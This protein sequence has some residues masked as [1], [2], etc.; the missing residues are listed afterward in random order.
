MR[1]GRG[2]DKKVMIMARCKEKDEAGNKRRNG[3]SKVQQGWKKKSTWGVAVI[4]G[5]W[6]RSQVL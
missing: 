1:T 2:N 4:T 6:G 5:E 3:E